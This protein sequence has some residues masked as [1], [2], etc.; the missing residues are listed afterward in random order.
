MTRKC[1]NHLQS[2]T[3]KDPTTWQRWSTSVDARINRAALRITHHHVEVFPKTT[4][5]FWA[6]SVTDR[7][8]KSSST[9]V[10]GLKVRPVELQR[11]RRL[12]R[13][14]DCPDVDD[15]IISYAQ[16]FLPL[17]THVDLYIWYKWIVRIQSYIVLKLVWL[18]PMSCAHPESGGGIGTYSPTLFVI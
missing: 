11:L 12:L 6:V 4:D 5:G 14:G 9:S 13:H 7:S 17:D 16:W 15:I 10:F 18:I 3:H 8:L 2:Y 1:L